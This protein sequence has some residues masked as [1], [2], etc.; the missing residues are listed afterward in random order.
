MEC[1]YVLKD[2]LIQRSENAVVRK[3]ETF[4]IHSMQVYIPNLTARSLIGKGGIGITNIRSIAYTNIVISTKDSCFEDMSLLLFEGDYLG[5][6]QAFNLV[7]ERILMLNP[8]LS[9]ISSNM[10]RMSALTDVIMN[11]SRLSS[12]NDYTLAF[13]RALNPNLLF[14]DTTVDS[15]E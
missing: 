6:P 14:V 1:F 8:R 7:L 12:S 13:M 10:R 11:S 2:D 5:I 15:E 9:W 4:Q 3:G